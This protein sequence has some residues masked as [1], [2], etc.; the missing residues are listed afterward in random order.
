MWLLRDT[1]ALLTDLYELTMAQA[2]FKHGIKEQAH[3][4]VTVRSLPANWVFFVMAGLAELQTYLEQFKFADQDIAFLESTETLSQDFLQYLAE[5]KPE[6]QIRALPEGTVFFG[7]EPVVEVG[8]AL[9]DAQIL[10]SYLLN[11]LGFSIIEATLAARVSIAA[12]GLPVVD[13]G[14]RRT[15]GP[16]AAVRAARGAQIA[17]FAA[18]SNVFAARALDFAPSGTMAHSYIQVHETEKEAFSEFAELY[19]ERAV[20]LIDTFD[21]VEGIKKAADVARQVYEEEGVQIKG[22]RLDSGDFLELSKFARRHFKEEGVP[23]LRILVSS[24]LDEYRIAEL[25][26]AGAEVDGFG[27]GTRFAVSHSVPDLDI[28]YK[29]IRYGNRDLFKKSADKQTRPGRKTILR[30]KGTDK[31]IPFAGDRPDDL[32]RVFKLPEP[33]D[34]IRQRLT[35]ELASL[36]NSVKAIKNPQSYP[37]EFTG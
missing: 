29:I 13:F 18:T 14:L 7:H 12:K 5:L 21:S 27:V 37:V 26:E 34:M 28:V 20:L 2:Y 1:P 3:F 16:V 4:E 30:T 9:I 17:G 24:G 35:A 23:F 15:Q 10:E 31:V 19:G 6:V 32:L 22:I 33:I 11:I 8:G 36:P 25:L